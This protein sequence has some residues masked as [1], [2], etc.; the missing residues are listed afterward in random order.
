ME[1][2]A[3]V[4]ELIQRSSSEVGLQLA[5]L[6]FIIKTLEEEAGRE[7][8]VIKPEGLTIRSVLWWVLW[9]CPDLEMAGPC[10]PGETGQENQL[11]LS[12]GAGCWL[13]SVSGAGI[14]PG[15]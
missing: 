15:W 1:R 9:A 14:T 4:V 5:G 7:R 11:L 6:R 13:V 8:Q 3:E 2:I 12:A 10:L